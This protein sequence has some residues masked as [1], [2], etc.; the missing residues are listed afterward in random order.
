[1]GK[2]SWK[3]IAQF[4]LKIAHRYANRSTF[5]KVAHKMKFPLITGLE[6][7]KKQWESLNP[8]ICRHKLVSKGSKIDFQKRKDT[9]LV[10]KNQN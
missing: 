7:L 1:M 3:E 5:Q 9:V 2:G 6:S 8:K 4:I 10:S